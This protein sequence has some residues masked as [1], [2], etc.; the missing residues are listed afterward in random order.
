MKEM[1][2]A[3]EVENLTLRYY[4]TEGVMENESG[5]TPIF[6]IFAAKYIGEEK[7]E[8]SDAGFISTDMAYV[9]ELIATLGKN[10]VTPMVLGEVLD[11]MLSA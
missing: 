8:E 5:K 3:V 1:V 9:D 7:E 2:L 6:G 4:R 11:D 10:T